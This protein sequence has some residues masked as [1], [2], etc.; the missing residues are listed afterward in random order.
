MGVGEL[1]GPKA[2]E[3]LAM[4]HCCGFSGDCSTPQ[5]AVSQAVRAI[6]G[7]QDSF[8]DG[9]ID[10]L[11]GFQHLITASPAKQAELHS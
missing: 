3:P 11:W 4:L 10:G 9:A 2:R 5:S 6:Q 8:S 1:R 7:A